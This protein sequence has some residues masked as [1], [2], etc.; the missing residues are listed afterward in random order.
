MSNKPLN[1]GLIGGGGGAFIVQPHQRAINSDGTRRVVAAALHPNPEIAMSEAANWPYEL[2]GYP[3][4]VEML[5]PRTEI[6]LPAR[7]NSVLTSPS[8]E[9]HDPSPIKART[10]AQ[11][12]K[13]L[14][15]FIGIILGAKPPAL[16][17]I[18]IGDSPYNTAGISR[19]HN[20]RRDV[21]SDN[22]ATS[23]H[24]ILSYTFTWI[25]YYPPPRATRH[26]RQL[27]TTRTQGVHCVYPYLKDVRQSATLFSGR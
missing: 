17:N 12:I 1:V 18:L 15:V 8:S 26:F 19:R 5:S 20:T 25:N 22:A 6:Y 10:T 23:Y 4:Y 9:T 11:I 27:S 3:S 14:T 21:M 2:K 16:F 24:G 7:S 13:L